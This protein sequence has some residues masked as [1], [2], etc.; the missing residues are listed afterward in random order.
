MSYEKAMRHHANIR[1]RKKQAT[2]SFGF[3][4]VTVKETPL[5]REA[6]CLRLEI[7]RWFKSRFDGDAQYNREC[8]RESI[9]SYRKLFTK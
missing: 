8:I 9:Q 2:M 7:T 4:A 6:I 5:D 3:D 1:K